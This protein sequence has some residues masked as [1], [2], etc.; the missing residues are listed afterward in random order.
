MAELVAGGCSTAAAADRLF[1]TPAT[2]KTHLA[3]IYRKLD[4]ANRAELAS[5]FAANAGAVSS[6]TRS[7]PAGERSVAR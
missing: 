2:V 1:V 6:R 4:I 7:A 5:T 3:H